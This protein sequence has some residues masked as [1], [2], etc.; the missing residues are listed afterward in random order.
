M[1]CQYD[2][3]FGLAMLASGPAVL[4]HGGGGS[5]MEPTPAQP[6]EWLMALMQM[7]CLHQE[8]CQ[9]AGQQGCTGKRAACHCSLCMSHSPPTLSTF[10]TAMICAAT[11]LLSG[12]IRVGAIDALSWL[13]ACACDCLSLAATCSHLQI[14]GQASAKH[15]PARD[16]ALLVHSSS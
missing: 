13:S 5:T 9:K 8:H 10:C 7:L 14:I 4:F 15:L 1:G 12:L 3:L 6:H 11:S 16:G 2:S